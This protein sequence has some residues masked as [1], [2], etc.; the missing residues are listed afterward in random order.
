MAVP[1]TPTGA[2][3]GRLYPRPAGG[4]GVPGGTG[5]PGIGAP[6][7]DG[8][9]IGGGAS[10]ISSP[11]RETRIVGA[12]DGGAVAAGDCQLAGGGASAAPPP[13]GAATAGCQDGAGA[14]RDMACTAAMSNPIPAG[15]PTTAC[16]FMIGLK[17]HSQ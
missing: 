7:I 13:S 11:V 1:G 14:E 15:A 3:P 12:V 2:E 9:I 4:M 6:G 10:S 5:P 16:A 17:H 8:G